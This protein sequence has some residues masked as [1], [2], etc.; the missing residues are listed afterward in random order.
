[1][2]Y[3]PT[4]SL[5]IEDSTAGMLAAKAGKMK[6]IAYAGGSHAHAANLRNVLQALSPDA[7]IDDMADLPSVVADLT[8]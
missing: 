7:L 4:T 3:D 1:M 2:G 8:G 6:T 5:V